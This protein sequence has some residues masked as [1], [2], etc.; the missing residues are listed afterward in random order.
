[1]SVERVDYYSDDE[2]EN[3]YY[4]CKPADAKK[5][6]E[7]E[8][9]VDWNKISTDRQ[10]MIV[11]QSSVRSACEYYK[12]KQGGQAGSFGEAMVLEFA[13]KIENYVM[14]GEI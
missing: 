2:Y 3:D 5:E 10:V 9:D 13:K 8:D 14:T 4:Q 7:R 6:D 12:H 11:R 1:M